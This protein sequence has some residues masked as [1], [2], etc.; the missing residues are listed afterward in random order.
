M[1]TIDEIEERR[2]KRAAEAKKAETEQ[3]AVD[4]S[5]LDELE[6]QHGSGCVVSVKCARFIPGLPTRVFCR[7]PRPDEYERYTST[8]ERPA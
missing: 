7:P 1:S 5:A 2:A 3:F 6:A 4:L 8:Y